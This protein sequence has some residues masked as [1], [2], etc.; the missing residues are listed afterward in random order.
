M[1][2]KL[3]VSGAMALGLVGCDNGGG[4]GTVRG[5]VLDVGGQPVRNARV[6]LD[7]RDGRSTL[8]NATG[9]F[10]LGASAGDHQIL[11]RAPVIDAGA[12]LAVTVENGD[13][14]D[15][16]NVT[17]TDCEEPQ[18]LPGE[19][20]PD[21][22]NDGGDPTNPCE[23]EPPPPPPDSITIAS[24][25]GDYGDAFVD[26]Y[27]VWGYLDDSGASAAMDFWFAGD[28]TTGGTKTVTVTDATSGFFDAYA[29]LFTYDSYGYYYMLVSGTLTI[30]VSDDGDADPT[31]MS[32]AFSGSN[33][34]FAYVDWYG[35]VGGATA[36]VGAASVNGLAWVWLPPEPPAADITIPTLVADWKE[37]YFCAACGFDGGDALY[38]Y[39]FDSLNGA[40][41]G[42]FLPVDALATPGSTAV[43]GSWDGSTGVFGGASY[44]HDAGVWYYDLGSATIDVG[45]DAIVVGE[46]LALSLT[47]GVFNYYWAD[48]SVGGGGTVEPQP[49]A[50]TGDPTTGTPTDPPE[51]DF[52]LFIGSADLSG[53]VNDFGCGNGDG[54]TPPPADGGTEP[55]V[56]PN[57]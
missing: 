24:L 13:V 26:G 12:S 17:V 46:N 36:S 52:H 23:Y 34:S 19:G 14:L 41:L 20:S 47:N 18:P 57:Q 40:D 11:A 44:Y 4:G 31:T 38:V 7:S 35:G 29:G 54:T 2:V 15:V 25:D 51:A 16:G 56:P 21:G 10:R 8:T 53:I 48:G 6:M 22:S 42:L 1:N 39:A 3:W 32:F 50:L 27:G 33:L 45:S 28:F 55:G 49:A 9:E 5:R 43:T 30:T 37:I